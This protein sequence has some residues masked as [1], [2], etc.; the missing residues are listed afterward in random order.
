MLQP[1]PLAVR[2]VLGKP[3]RAF[4][5][6]LHRPPQGGIVIELERA[7]PRRNHMRAVEEAVRG[8]LGAYNLRGLC[9]ETA[10]IFRDLAGYDRVMLYRFD[11]DGHGEV[12]FRGPRRGAGAVPRQPLPG[13]RH[14]AD[15]PS[16]V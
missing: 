14:P 6:A 4:D 9:D 10:R 1:V 15:R 13:H 11:P 5:V 7:M 8:I 3:A 12:L 2:C 16:P